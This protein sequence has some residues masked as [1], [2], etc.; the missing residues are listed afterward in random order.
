L[1]FLDELNSVR[2]DLHELGDI[3]QLVNADMLLDQGVRLFLE[4]FVYIDLLRVGV[5]HDGVDGGQGRVV[6]NKRAEG[7]IG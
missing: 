6:V 7:S 4:G 2:I 1:L 5:A 3:L